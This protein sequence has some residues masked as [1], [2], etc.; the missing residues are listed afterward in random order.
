MKDNKNMAT[1]IRL[2]KMVVRPTVLWVLKYA[3]AETKLRIDILER[4][5]MKYSY[6]GTGNPRDNDIKKTAAAG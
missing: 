6:K 5:I 4:Q 2:Y 3:H 1:K